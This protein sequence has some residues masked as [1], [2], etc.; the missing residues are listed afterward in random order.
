VGGLIFGGGRSV[1]WWLLAM[2]LVVGGQ[3][4]WW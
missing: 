3:V 1:D 2:V 4:G